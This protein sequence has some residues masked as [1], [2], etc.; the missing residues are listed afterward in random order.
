M[1]KINKVCVIGS[2]AMGS[3][4]AAQVAN[5]RTKVLLMDVVATD[6]NDPDFIIKA[7]LGKLQT[8]KPSPLS[9]PDLLEYITIGNLRDN[10]DL[11]RDC[12]LIIE[13]IIERLDIKHQLYEIIIPYLKENAIISSNTSTLPL[14]ELKKNLPINIQSRFIITH[15][16]N[17][18]RFMELVEIVTDDDVYSGNINAVQEFITHR[19]GKTVVLCNDTPGFIANRI[20]C[21]LLELAVR[22]GLNDGIKVRRIDQIFT[23]F[24]GF[25]STGIF[26]LYDLIGHDVMALISKSLTSCLPKEDKYLEI[27]QENLTLNKMLAHGMLGRKS[28]AGFY[29]QRKEND[30]KIQEVLDPETFSY[31]SFEEEI[32][33]KS[34]EGLLAGKD[35]KYFTE[36]LQIFFEYVVNLIPTV[37]EDPADIDTAMRLGYSL[38]F[39]PFELITNKMPKGVK[40]LE[41]IDKN[42]TLLKSGFKKQSASVAHEEIK[43]NGSA[44]LLSKEGALVFEINSK[45]NSLNLDVFNL[46]IES[47]KIAEDK[48]QNLYIYPSD[49]CF[50]AGADLKYIKEN[51]EAK[52]FTAIESYID[53]GQKAMMALKYS[54]CQVIACAKGVA[55]GGGCEILL[56]S[57][58][59]IMHQNLNAGLVEMGVGLIPG[60]GGVKEMFLRS[61]GN[62]DKLVLLLR[63]ILEQNKTSSADYFDQDYAI[64]GY[65]VMNKDYLLKNAMAISKNY[66]NKRYLV[67]T[68]SG[69]LDLGESIDLS[70][71]IDTSNYDGLQIEVL[72]FFQSIIDR[73]KLSEQELLQLEKSKFLELIEQPLCLK[74][75]SLFV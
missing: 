50:S 71:A 34:I 56:H 65:V 45:M 11:I 18:P 63:N 38:K 39:G 24:F 31:V 57:D 40:W 75:L 60:W 19:L 32:L 5:S 4:I 26:G 41:Q 61:A 22:K 10:L 64:S 36:I 59:V 54:N 33:P 13:V 51:I 35:G 74:R 44:K 55:L 2:G 47:C 23:K 21:F 58:I 46:M 72:Q 20:G 52:N 17:P 67:D 12:D 73:K 14:K 28:G 15:F 25:P 16:F 62:K 7:A 69:V 9:H 27:Y 3:G 43:I 70:K 37:A 49:P 66:V 8:Q 48:K 29:R 68:T 30:L 1:T 42:I 53:L 6:N